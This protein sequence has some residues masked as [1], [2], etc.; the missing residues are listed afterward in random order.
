MNIVSKYLYNRF[1]PGQKRWYP[2]IAV[3]YLNYS[4]DFRC[5]Y[6][7]DG[8]G[9]PYYELPEVRTTVAEAYGIIRRIRQYAG[10]FVLTG[11]EPLQYE[12]IGE[13][14]PMI[15]KL[16]FSNFVFTTNGY[17]FD[18][19]QEQIM[20]SVDSL[21]FSLDTLNPAKSVAMWGMAEGTFDKVMSNIL[22]AASLKSKAGASG[23]DIVISSVVTPENIEDLYDVYEFSMK[24]GFEF[25]ACPQLM[26]VKA[27]HSLYGNEAYRRFYDFLIGEKKKRRKI[28][29]SLRYLEYMRDLKTF[30]C[31]PFTMLVVSPAGEIYYPCLERG[32]PA[33]NIM[34]TDNLHAA[35]ELGRE[36]YGPKPECGNQC[37]SA[38][39]LTFGLIV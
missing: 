17:Y 20:D 6:C 2:F 36:K 25:A 22:L 37:H 32:R 39:A 28:Y 35:R 14:L 8:S 16:K 30:T 33:C 4:C 29:G 38:C 12:G 27:H 11:G 21:V 3:Y 9:K 34:D 5:S 19:Y 18:D 13:L 10:Y 24:S 23:P 15:K 7:S 31:K 26:G 1:V